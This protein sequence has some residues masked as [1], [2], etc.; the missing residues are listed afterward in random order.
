MEAWIAILFQPEH[1]YIE[2]LDVFSTKEQLEDEVNTE[3]DD[4]Y[5]FGPH[6]VL[7]DPPSIY[8]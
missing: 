4:V 7:N 6:C 3:D 2:V 8:T 1:Q 5:V